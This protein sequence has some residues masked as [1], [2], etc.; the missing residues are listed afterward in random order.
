MPFWKKRSDE[1][2]F[3]DHLEELR[4]RILWSLLAVT[5][6]SVIGFLLVMKLN[7]LGILIR[8]IEPFLEGS[9]LKYLG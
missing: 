8:P 3:L 5:F 2:P 1:M 7:V 4:W 9:R 6:A